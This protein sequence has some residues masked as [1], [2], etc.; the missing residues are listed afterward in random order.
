MIVEL[1]GPPGAGKSTIAKLVV[2]LLQEKG[3]QALPAGE[4]AQ[5][6]L[7]RMGT[8]Q[9]VSPWG[10][11][12]VW[13][14]LWFLLEHPLLMWMAFSAQWKRPIPLRHRYWVLRWF[15]K[16]CGL[17][18]FLCRHLAANEAAIF[19]EGLV[20]RAV[21]LFASDQ[22]PPSSRAVECYVRRLPRSDLLIAVNAPP[23]LCVERLEGR[24][25]PR[26]LQDLGAEAIWSFV[27][28]QADAVAGAVAEAQRCGWPLL[29]VDNTVSLAQVREQL[30]VGLENLPEATGC[31]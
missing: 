29:I 6:I 23:S 25:L 24:K 5:V 2:N 15:L 19:D 28:H 7:G 17:Y 16:T 26:R 20:H 9:R 18:R 1:T 4:T 13:H 11:L 30:W 27:Q 21:T 14:A 31:L 12:E 8:G 3:I 22:E 10:V